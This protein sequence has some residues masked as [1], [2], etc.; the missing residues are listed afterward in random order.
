MFDLNT[1]ISLALS[2]AFIVGGLVALCWSADR[3]IAAA[4]RIARALGMSS[5]IVGMVVIGFGTSAPELAVSV[6]S[7]MAKHSNLSLG[8]AYGSCIFNNALILGVSSVIWPLKVK[9][10]ICKVG[11]PLLTAVTLLSYLLVKDLSFTRMNGALLLAVFAVMM[12]AYCL[13]DQKSLNN[14]P[15]QKEDAEPRPSLRLVD[16]AWLVGG[17]V[18]LVASSHILV[19]G[20][21]DFARDVLHVDDLIIGLTI[22]AAGTS[23]PE[24]ASAVASARR[25]EHEFVIGNIVGSN[26]FNMLGVVGLAGVIAPFSGYSRYIVT[27][28]MPVMFAMTVSILLFGFDWRSRGREAGQIGRIEGAIWIL[29]F[30][31]YVCMMIC[32]ETI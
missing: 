29:S 21:V 14:A 7:G 20:C 32:Q 8:N 25:G 22:V 12:P 18:L 11:V 19:W 28:D 27:R 3:F 17:L 31:A 15:V 5:L 26:L 24:L 16:F 13:Y 6:L 2:L 23:L 1:D 9:P 30:V 4:A 10:S